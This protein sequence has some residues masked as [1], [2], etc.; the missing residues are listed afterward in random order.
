MMVPA[1]ACTPLDPRHP[2][3]PQLASFSGV[4]RLALNLDPSASRRALHLLLFKT[5]IGNESHF[6]HSSQRG[7]LRHE[8]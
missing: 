3:S 7:T 8:R 4:L 6:A 5:V 2:E 1:R